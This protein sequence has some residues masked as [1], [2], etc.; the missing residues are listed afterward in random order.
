MLRS[1]CWISLCRAEISFR[2]C[3]VTCVSF[4]ICGDSQELEMSEGNKHLVQKFN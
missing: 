1:N 3:R 4:S 2:A